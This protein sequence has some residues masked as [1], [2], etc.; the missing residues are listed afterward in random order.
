VAVLAVLLGVFAVFMLFTPAELDVQQTPSCGTRDV[1]ILMAQSVPSATAVPCI[2]TLP[3]GW[4]LGGVEVRQDKARFWLNSDRGGDRAVEVRLVAPDQ[5]AIA[6]A[7]EVPSNQVGM[8]RFERPEQLPP[9]LQSTRYYVFDGG[10]VIYRFAFDADASAS[11]MFSAESAL[12]FEPRQALVE[13]VHRDSGLRLCGAG[14]PPCPG[15]S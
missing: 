12:A 4:K 10:C 7:T 11:L 13:R 5:C 15:G 1:M 3:A 9:R 14:V 8:R 2:A 6:G